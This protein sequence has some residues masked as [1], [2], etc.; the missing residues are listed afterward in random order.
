MNSEKFWLCETIMRYSSL[1]MDSY[2]HVVLF[3][4]NLF[5]KKKTFYMGHLGQKFEYVRTEATTLQY[6]F[7]LW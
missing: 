2:V 4:F 5:L 1:W 7:L 3:Y 6:E